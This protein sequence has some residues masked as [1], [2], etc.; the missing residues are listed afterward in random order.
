M[1]TKTLFRKAPAWFYWPRYFISHGLWLRFFWDLLD[2]NL[3]FN[4]EKPQLISLVWLSKISTSIIWNFQA[5]A[6]W[7]ALAGWCSIARGG[8]TKTNQTLGKY[9]RRHLFTRNLIMSWLNQSESGFYFHKKWN[10]ATPKLGSNYRRISVTIE[11]VTGIPIT[12]EET[13]CSSFKVNSS[14][15]TE[16]SFLV[17]WG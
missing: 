12:D 16:L 4:S 3:L 13:T 7:E 6:S 9:S 8:E 11:N 15:K 5:V 14:L 17:T 1:I 10:M 2:S